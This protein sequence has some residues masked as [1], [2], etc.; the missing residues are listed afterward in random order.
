[1]IRIDKKWCFI[2]REHHQGHNKEPSGQ[3]TIGHRERDDEQTFA[4]ED[5][6]RYHQSMHHPMIKE[7]YA[8]LGNN[9]LQMGQP[10]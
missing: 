9:Y 6:P 8:H 1:V 4:C 7:I 5:R 2:D 10:C 3:C